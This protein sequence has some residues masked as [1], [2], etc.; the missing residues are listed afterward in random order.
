MSV[1]AGTA[2]IELKPDWAGFSKELSSGL[3]RAGSG[4]TG[5]GKQMSVAVTAPILAAAGAAGFFGI[6]TAASLEQ[7]EVAFATLTGS[8][9]TG[10]KVMADLK[11]L[12]AITPFETAD[13]TTTAQRLL[14]AGVATEDLTRAITFLGD[15]AGTQGAQ[16][17]DR[18]GFAYAQI[19]G[20]GRAMTEDINQIADVGVPIWG[21]LAAQLGVTQAQVRTMASEGK[22]SADVITAAFEQP[23]GPMQNLVGGM[24]AQ[25]QTLTGLW[26]TF[27]DTVGQGLADSITASLPDI[28]S[29]LTD[30]TA[31]IGPALT[32]A[33]PAFAGIAQAIVP[34][35]GALA[36][37]LV[38]F[39]ELSP[40]MQKWIVYA[41]AG[42]A[43]VGPVALGLGRVA[44]AAS[45][46]GG[47]LAKVSGGFNK[48]VGAIFPVWKQL[49]LFGK[50]A[51]VLGKFTSILGT[52]GRT[53]F[54]F[55]K[56]VVT[57]MQII[58]A[59]FAA[60]PIGL[61][62]VAIGIAVVL[63]IKYWD[64]IKGAFAAAW[65]V[66]KPVLEGLW[67]AVKGAF[68]AV[69]AAIRAAIAWI[70]G[71]FTSI[72]AAVK[73]VWDTFWSILTLPIRIWWT[74]VSAI[75]QVAWAFLQ[76][77]F[78]AIVGFVAPIWQGLWDA[79]SGA[80]TAAWGFIAGALS[81]AWAFIVAVFEGI[82]SSVLSVWN[83]LWGAVRAA[84][85]AVYGFL[86]GGITR[87]KDVVVN[88]FTTM[89]DKVK[90]VWD[91]I[92]GIVQGAVD[93][94]QGIASGIWNGLKGVINTGIGLLNAAIRGF[95]NV[96]SAVNRVPG[97]NVPTIPSI[98]RLAD[99]GIVSRPTIAMV[100][101]A[102]PEAVIP[103]SRLAQHVPDQ[104]PPG[105]AATYLQVYIGDTEITSMIERVNRRDEQRLAAA[106]ARGRRL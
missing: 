96:I 69:V 9:E 16:G 39:S 63:V 51:V 84:W 2:F 10:R 27:K 61:L 91:S 32:A 8:A 103:L 41:V 81:A 7:A 97:V 90:G 26:S 59:A 13:L 86:S 1:S 57:V 60:N 11:A 36:D 23:L 48:V 25:S 24:A 99:G 93:A 72:W 79:V 47:M 82:R 70:G 17:L 21:E 105:P 53:L 100:G 102:G 98:P 33:G 76:A 40:E 85:D 6:T 29:A 75:I 50:F 71:L 58:G 52:V 49:T 66:I 101:E 78:A 30:I 83:G 12:G 95:N 55:A 45:K 14:N 74:V 106:L 104:R 68:D 28:K 94:V 20:S 65:N 31:A 38:W 62:V 4:L 80:L 15:A 42:A 19:L 64:Q 18:L 43:A 37:V 89:R 92:R 54:G 88:A 46:T 73:P 35:V 34:L 44:T 67:Q 56:G 87:A 5:F 77:A 3:S 22:I